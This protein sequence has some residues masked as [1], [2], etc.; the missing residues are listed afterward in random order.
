MY[1]SLLVHKI[2]YIS[3]TDQVQKSI[4]CNMYMYLWEHLSGHH[5]PHSLKGEPFASFLQVVIGIIEWTKPNGCADGNG[6]LCAFFFVNCLNYHHLNV[7][8]SFSYMLKA[9]CM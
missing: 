3:C 9:A 4:D 1:M 6:V 7:I 2:P 5:V 8:V